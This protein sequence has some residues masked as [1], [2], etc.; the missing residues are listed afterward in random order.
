MTRNGMKQIS[1]WLPAEMVDEIK[2]RLASQGRN[3]KDVITDAFLK[4]KAENDTQ[5]AITAI[6]K[7][8]DTIEKSL[9]KK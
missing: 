8:L 9:F 5:K 3:M 6:E 4:L 7:R 1:A 2:E